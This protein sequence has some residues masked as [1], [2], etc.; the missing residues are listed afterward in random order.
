MS[1]KRSSFFGPVGVSPKRRAHDSSVTTVRRSSVAATATTHHH[2]T[3][4]TLV[5]QGQSG[6]TPQQANHAQHLKTHLDA[7]QQAHIKV[8]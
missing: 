8:R 2:A 1:R 5:R 3:E 4:L 7:M 6:S